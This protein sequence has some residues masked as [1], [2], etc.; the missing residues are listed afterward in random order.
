MLDD[1]SAHLGGQVAR[2]GGAGEV[3]LVGEY[4]GGGFDVAHDG[5]GAL[6]GPEVL[7]RHGIERPAQVARG[8][9]HLARSET[10]AGDD[11]RQLRVYR[12]GLAE[13]VY[14]GHGRPVVAR[15]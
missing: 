1:L 6:V 11:E 3:A 2:L 4:V 13:A 7:R 10:D 9:L 8:A 12:R 5:G 14:L 15:R